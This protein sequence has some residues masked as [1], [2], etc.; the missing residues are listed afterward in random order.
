MNVRQYIFHICN[1]DGVATALEMCGLSGDAEVPGV[2]I[3]LLDQHPGAHHVTA[4]DGW[5]KVH[6]HLRI[7][8]ELRDVLSRPP[9]G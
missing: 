6:T 7:D 2:A 9:G 4:W 8:P 1:A 3:N 5:R